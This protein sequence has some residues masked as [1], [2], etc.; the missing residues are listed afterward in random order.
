MYMNVHALLKEV[1]NQYIWHVFNGVNQLNI[2]T[3]TFQ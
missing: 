2:Y 3:L 1:P